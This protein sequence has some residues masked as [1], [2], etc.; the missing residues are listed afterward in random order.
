MTMAL[1]NLVLAFVAGVLSIL[2]PCVLPIL[3]IVLGAASSAERWGPVAL[4]AGLALS[5]TALGLFVATIGYSIGLDADAFRY[6]AAVLV[7]AIG[8][9]LTVP[10]LHTQ[11]AT[12]SGPIANWTDQRF[13]ARHGSG[14]SGQFSI[15]VLL[16]AVWSPC[17]GPTLG[18]ASLLA[19]QGQDVP[20]VGATMFVFGIGAALPLLLLGRLSRETMSRW[21]SRLMSAGHLAKTGLGILFI[22]I[23]GLVLTGADKLVEAALVASSPQWL[24]DLTTRF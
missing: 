9:V 23:G 18:A 1:G 4:A 11:L 6:A 16:G 15:G 2:S 12:A 19:A 3:P 5:F 24:T 22:A 20:Q 14:I 13:G 17:V 21:R 8:I 10:R 7:V